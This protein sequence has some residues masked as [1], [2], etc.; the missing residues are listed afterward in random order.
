[1]I[2]YQRNISLKLLCLSSISKDVKLMYERNNE[3]G[4]KIMLRD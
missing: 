3:I 4:F 2:L 1:M